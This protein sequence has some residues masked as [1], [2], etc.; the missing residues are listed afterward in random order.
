MLSSRNKNSHFCLSQSFDFRSLSCWPPTSSVSNYLLKTKMGFSNQLFLA[1]WLFGVQTL[2]STV[3][4]QLSSL[5]F[6]NEVNHFPL[7]Y[8]YPIQYLQTGNGTSSYY[9]ST[10][11]HNP[12]QISSYVRNQ[13]LMFD[14]DTNS[15]V[16]SENI[17]RYL[18]QKPHAF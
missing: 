3:P 9:L 18:T 17:Y 12:M 8:Q 13:A 15:P 10:D 4:L 1:P 7:W 2:P 6:K 11:K 5:N 14:S 16:I